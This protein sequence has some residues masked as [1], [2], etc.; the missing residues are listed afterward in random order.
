MINIFKKILILMLFVIPF[1]VKAENEVE[2]N[3]VLNCD[4]TKLSPGATT[5][6]TLKVNVTKGSIYDIDTRVVF[7]SNLSLDGEIEIASGMMG[8]GEENRITIQP[9]SGDA[10]TGLIDVASFKIKASNSIID[11]S[12]ESIGVTST[13]V[14]YDLNNGYTKQLDNVTK[15]IRIISNVNTL[16][17]LTLSTGTL[18]PKFSSGTTNYSATVD[19]SKVTINAT[20]SDN[21][22][23]LSGDVG[24]VSLKYGVNTFNINVVSESGVTKVYTISITRPDNRDDDN[25]LSSLKLNDNLIELKDEQDEYSLVVENEVTE[26]NIEAILNSDKST[27]VTDFEP[28]VVKLNEGINKFELKVKAENETVRTYTLNV[29]RKGVLINDG[30]VSGGDDGSNTDGSNNGDKDLVDENVEPIPTGS[31]SLYIVL[32]IIIISI[33]VGIFYYNKYQKNQGVT[34]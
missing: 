12:N 21:S 31:L 1:N 13:D 24:E 17:S 27:F 8:D 18:S 6:C 4:K 20:K 26:L 23:T 30:D 15:D 19:A 2:A 7:S 5:T 33:I 9:S 3:M 25:S 14:T 10:V 22:S 16:S 34:K 28:R 29:N 32:G 11:G